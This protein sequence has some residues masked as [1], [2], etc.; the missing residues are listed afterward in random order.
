MSVVVYEQLG[1]VMG[2]QA[3]SIAAVKNETSDS[4]PE[5]KTFF[6]MNMRNAE[7][8]LNIMYNMQDIKENEY[9]EY[10]RKYVK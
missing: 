8:V 7:Y 10:V 6:I 4:W 2:N 1:P 3:I 9:A 5:A